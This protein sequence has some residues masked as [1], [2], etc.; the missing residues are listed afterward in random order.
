[1]FTLGDCGAAIGRQCSRIC[2]SSRSYRDDTEEYILGQTELG[3]FSRD[4]NR[5]RSHP[6][7]TSRPDTRGP[8]SRGLSSR[9][10]HPPITSQAQPYHRLYPDARSRPENQTT[11]YPT[12]V[13]RFQE[14]TYSTPSPSAQSASANSQ[15]LATPGKSSRPSSSSRQ[16]P[17]N[18]RTRVSTRESHSRGTQN[19]RARLDPMILEPNGYAYVSPSVSTRRKTAGSVANSELDESRFGKEHV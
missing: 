4:S 13:P 16:M 17:S 3:P 18:P 7:P 11:R 6:T 8:D 12:Q 2:G 19:I 1:M 9:H 10:P 14:S 5:R 15:G